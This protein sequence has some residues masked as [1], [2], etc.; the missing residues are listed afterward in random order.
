MNSKKNFSFFATVT[1]FFCIFRHKYQHMKIWKLRLL[2]AFLFFGFITVFFISSCEKNVCNNVTCFNGG[3][4]NSGVC[5]CPVG[6]EG[7]QCSILSV[8]RIIGGYA[9]LVK[10]GTGAAEIDS[11]WVVGDSKNINFVYITEKQLPGV[12]LHGYV[13][14]NDASFSIIV[15]ADSSINFLE[16]FNI[17]LQD[18]S[19]LSMTTYKHD[20][21][22][23]GDTIISTCTFTAT[24]KFKL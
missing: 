16:I 10:C 20:E 6:W 12:M 3:S 1:I 18:T 5:K 23:V 7:P 17:T 13:N 24:R 11:V 9:G 4:C 8:N 2:T 21:T 22:K 14:E 19:R 15:P